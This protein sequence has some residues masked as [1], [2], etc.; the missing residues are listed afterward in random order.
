MDIDIIREARRVYSH[1]GEAQQ[2][3]LP[4]TL[5]IDEWIAIIERLSGLCAY[6]ACQ[7]FET[8][9][10]LIPRQSGGGTVAENC[11]PACLVCNARTNHRLTSALGD[12]I[13]AEERLSQVRYA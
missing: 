11:I 2:S 7:P 4:C 3:G 6:C 1:T 8:L 12:D 5:T 13:S 10:H 9:D